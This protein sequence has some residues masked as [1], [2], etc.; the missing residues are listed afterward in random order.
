MRQVKKVTQCRSCGA[1]DMNTV[2]DMGDLK[3]NAF[4]VEPNTD[5]GSAPM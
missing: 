3:I 5:V 4:T 1:D 2:F